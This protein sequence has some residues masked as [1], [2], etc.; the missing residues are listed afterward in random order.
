M[1]ESAPFGMLS[2]ASPSTRQFP[3]TFYRIFFNIAHRIKAAMVSDFLGTLQS[4]GDY[5]SIVTIK[6]ILL[7]NL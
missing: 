1:D 7:V 5:I 2:Y 6:K 3:L 4:I